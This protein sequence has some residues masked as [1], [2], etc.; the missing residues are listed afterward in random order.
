[1]TQLT[2]INIHHITHTLLQLISQQNWSRFESVYMTVCVAVI[3]TRNDKGVSSHWCRPRFG[4]EGGEASER[5]EDE[6]QELFWEA[7][8]LWCGHLSH[9]RLETG[10]SRWP[11]GT[12]SACVCTSVCADASISDSAGVSL[13]AFV[14]L[15]EGAVCTGVCHLN[16]RLWVWV[17]VLDGLT[18]LW[19]C[20]SVLPDDVCPPT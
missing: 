4:K 17:S 5:V 7:V 12:Y 19:L 18:G 6:R 8:I 11:F 13:N 10:A 2:P 3:V 14:V 1:M 15:C 16:I 20:H 9:L